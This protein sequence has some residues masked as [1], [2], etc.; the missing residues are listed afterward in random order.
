MSWHYSF[1]HS[2]CHNALG[3]QVRNISVN[4]LALLVEKLCKR[5]AGADKAFA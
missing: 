4:R 2:A 1:K 3:D 5:S